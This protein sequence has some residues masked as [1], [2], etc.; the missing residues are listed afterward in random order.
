MY[1]EE[2][3]EEEEE[4]EGCLGAVSINIKAKIST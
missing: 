2:E 3:E 4:E 1:D